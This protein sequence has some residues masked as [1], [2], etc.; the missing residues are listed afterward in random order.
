MDFKDETFIVDAN[1]SYQSDMSFGNEIDRTEIESDYNPFEF[2]AKAQS[3]M[4]DL[5]KKN[6]RQE[7]LVKK[8]NDGEY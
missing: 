5:I 4:F 1:T 8:Q 6:R 7:E 3:D 2:E